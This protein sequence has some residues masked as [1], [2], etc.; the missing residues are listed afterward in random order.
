[1]NTKNGF[2]SL[3]MIS[4]FF[5]VIIAQYPPPAGQSGTT[6]IYKDSSIFV[7]WA[8]GCEVIRG[9][10]NIMDLQGETASFG[11][12]LNAAGIAEGNS[13]DVVSLGD[14][15]QATLT[16]DVEIADGE[17]WDFAVFENALND[18]FLEL[19]FVAVSSD[20]EDFYSFPAV[21]LTDQFVQVSTFGEL[22]CTK[23]NNFAGKYR[24]GLGTP[25]DLAE[26]N[27]IAGLDLQKVTHIRII[28]AI[29]CIQNQFASFDSQGHVV[30]D[31]WPTAFDTGGFDLDGVGVIHTSNTGVV[32]N[33]I[34]F[35]VFPNPFADSFTVSTATPGKFV[36]EIY[37][38][39]GMMLL[40]KQMNST[41]NIDFT[42]YPPGVCFL[43]IYSDKN[44]VTRKIIK[45]R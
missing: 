21:S 4:C 31:P 34:S 2:L 8:T 3:L 13:V 36:I 18:T 15:G 16:F 10:I 42:V 26:L 20:G 7:A 11:D 30:N 17:G 27:G 44:V 32:E 24:Q 5:P 45:S 25:F 33:D 29:G 1:M 39:R 41:L 22:D 19:A 14:M 6:A 43:K 40:R 38:A 28:D 23:V 12:P 35:S 9:P 37:S